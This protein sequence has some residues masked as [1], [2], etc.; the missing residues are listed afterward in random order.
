MAHTYSHL[1]NIPSTGL[2]FFTVYGPWGRPDMAISVL[3][4]I[5]LGKEIKVFNAGKMLRDFTYIDDIVNGIQSAVL[6]I[7]G[8]NPAWDADRAD[9]ASSSTPFKIYNLGHHQPVKLLDFISTL[10]I[11]LG[12]KPSEVD[13]DATGDVEQTFADIKEASRPGIQSYDRY[14]GRP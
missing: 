7:P 9:P 5:F 13:A 4:G 11:L 2:R 1:F 6:K 3:H 14:S 8:S 12:K 10:E